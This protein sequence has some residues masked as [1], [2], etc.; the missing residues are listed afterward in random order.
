MHGSSFR[1][2]KFNN[3]NN[4]FEQTRKKFYTIGK[5]LAYVHYV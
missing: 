3:N 1:I 2:F 5:I 4:N